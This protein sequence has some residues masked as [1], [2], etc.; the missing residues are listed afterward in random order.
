MNKYA[1]FE[2]IEIIKWKNNN[3]M[4]LLKELDIKMKLLN[5]RRNTEYKKIKIEFCYILAAFAGRMQREVKTGK[6]WTNM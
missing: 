6:N 1:I 5:E 2:K 3:W 4:K